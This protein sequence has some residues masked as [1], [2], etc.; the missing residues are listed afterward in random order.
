LKRCD[1]RVSPVS[2]HGVLHANR[3]PVSSEHCVLVT[4]PVV[5]HVNVAFEPELDREVKRTVGAVGV[6]FEV[7]TDQFH[8][9]LELPKLFETVTRKLWLPTARPEY[10][11]GDVHA[12]GVALSSEQVVLETVPPVVHEKDALVDVVDEDGAPVKD[13]VGAEPLG[14]GVLPVPESS[15]VPN[16]CDQ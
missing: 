5:D 16:S 13:T 6:G 4:V 14:G 15:K 3:G 8:V 2:V 7:V 11:F 1:P 12:V 9:A 10:D